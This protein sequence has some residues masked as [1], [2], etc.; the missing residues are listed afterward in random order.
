MGGAER[1]LG[2]AARARLI[3]SATIL[4][5]LLSRE[6][7]KTLVLARSGGLCV[8]CPR[9]AIEAHHILERKLFAN[10]GYYASNG[11]AVCADHHWDCEA[12][13]LSVEA[14]RAAAG[15]TTVL[16][17]EGLLA[18]RL[19]D[20]WGTRIWPSGLRSWGPLEGDV[21]A[22]RAL[23]AGGLLGRMMPASHHELDGSGFAQGVP[24]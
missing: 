5:R 4:E 12:T 20:K 19:Y 2:T 7:F 23:A 3:V 1:A 21:G 6:A 11:A 17:P 9:P 24:S 18:G 16:L 15:I 10:G 22:R 14:V 8:F 13:R